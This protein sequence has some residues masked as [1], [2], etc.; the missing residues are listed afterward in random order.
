MYS[1]QLSN[2]VQSALNISAEIVCWTD[3]KVVLHWINSDSNRW[4]KFVSN[5]VS[6]IQS[7]TRC[8]N[9]KF[10]DGEHNPADAIS[11]GK[12]TVSFVTPPKDIFSSSLPVD[13]HCDDETYLEKR[14]VLNH[15]HT[16]EPVIDL[17]RF[18]SFSFL[19][20]V[21]AWIFR[22]FDV[23]AKQNRFEKLDYVSAKELNN[24]EIF[25]IRE[26]QQR[27]FSSQLRLIETNEKITDSS[28]QPLRPFLDEN[29]ILRADRRLEYSHLSF[30]DRYPII[31]PRNGKFTE[32][33]LLHIHQRILHG[34]VDRTV[35][36]SRNK[37]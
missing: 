24:A 22:I 37:Y 25:W 3:S 33:L 10:V 36:E 21:T 12:P 4:K 17:N 15:V 18:S 26:V 23:L 7:L 8:T 27:A 35:Q 19:L 20:C 30:N 32:L 13:L 29:Q 14:K 2:Y 28:L 1:A 9:W 31:L 16:K 6:K 5:R 11:R 34:S